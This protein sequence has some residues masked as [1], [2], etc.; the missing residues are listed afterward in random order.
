MMNLKESITKTKT[1]TNSAPLDP[2]CCKTGCPDCPYGYQEQFNPDVPIELQ[3]KNASEN[4]PEGF[5]KYLEVDHYEEL[6][7]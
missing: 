6:N 7:D 3:K 1:Q 2:R 5:E 4:L